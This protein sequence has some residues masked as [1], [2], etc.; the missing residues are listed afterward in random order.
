[1]VANL[2]AFKVQTYNLKGKKLITFGKRGKHLNDFHGCCNPVTVA[3]LSNN[4]IVTAEKDPT[5]IKVYSKDGAHLIEGIEELVKGCSYIP[6]VVD[7]KDNIYLASSKSGI[8]KCV[9]K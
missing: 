4:A 2:A 3:S 1:M 9:I 5:R 8:I 6:M 7:G